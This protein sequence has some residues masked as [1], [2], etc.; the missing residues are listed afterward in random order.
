MKALI[1]RS[2]TRFLRDNCNR[3]ACNI[4]INLCLQ[5]CNYLFVL[6]N[7]RSRVAGIETC[8]SIVKNQVAR[9][10]D[11][12]MANLLLQL[13]K[14]FATCKGLIKTIRQVEDDF[15][16]SDAELDE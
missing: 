15:W 11:F 13:D 6:H 1:N 4:S 12:T 3:L 2:D 7:I 10:C 5:R 9:N 16:T 8:W 14:A